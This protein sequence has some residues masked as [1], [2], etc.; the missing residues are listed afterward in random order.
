MRAVWSMAQFVTLD[1][2]PVKAHSAPARETLLAQWEAQ[3]R[4]AETQALSAI[5]D[6]ALGRRAPGGAALPEAG[7]K[8]DLVL[9]AAVADALRCKSVF[10]RYELLRMVNRHLPSYL[11]GLPGSRVTELLEELTARALAPGGP[12]GTVLLTA[13]DMVPVPAAYRRADGLSRGA[14][15]APRYTTRDQLGAEPRL[16][17]VAAQTGAPSIA[18]DRAARAL[19]ANRARLEARLW[20]EHGPQGG[21]GAHPALD[22]A[23]AP[24]TSA[25]LSDDQAQAAYG[26]L[27]SGRAIDILIGAAGTG[28]TRTVAVLARAWRDAGIG[29]VVGLTTS[30]S[31]AHTLAAEGLA[32]SSNLAVFL[33]RIKDS[34]RTRGHRPVRPGDLLVVDE[35]SMVPTGDLAAVEAI[36][37]RV[38]AKIL[39]TGDP[40]QLSSPGAG[41]AMRL[42]ADE[43]GY[44]QL[45]TVQRFD[46][47][48]EREASL[49]LRAAD[50]DVLAEYD[51]RGRILEGTAEEMAAAAVRR[52][53]ADYL[54]GKESLLMAGTNV[55]A[56]DLA[57]RARDSLAALGVVG[58]DDLIELADGNVAGPGDLIVARQN[59]RIVAGEP[60]RLLANRDLL[61]IDAWEERGEERVAVVRRRTGRDPVTGD[62][63]WSAPF[64]L[65]ESYLERHVQ[66]GYAGNVHVA[67][68]RTVDTT[69]LLVDESVGREALYVGLGR[70]RQR[71]TA[72]TIT[73]RTRAA[74][75]S[76]VPR[77]APELV[78][79]GAGG[80]SR[81]HRFTVLAAVMEREQS[82]RTATETVR[83]ELERAASL[84]TLAPMWADVTR[85]HAARRYEDSIRALIAEADW[86]QYDQ[87]AERGTLI[88]LLRAAELAGHDVDSV[89]RHAVEDRGFAG[90]RSIA[91]VLHGRVRR[92]VGTAEPM[93]S[94][95]Y[96]D[97]TPVI[98]DPAARRLAGELAAAMDERVALLGERV[99]ADRP[100]WVL[101]HLG[102]VPTGA[103]DRDEWARRAGLA[104]AYR[105]ER[106]YAS[107]TD[108]LGPAPERASPE[109][110]ASWH[111]AYA[112]LRMPEQDREVAAATDG[113]LLSWR[114]AYEREAGWAPL[115]VV[116]ELRE[117]HIAEDTY[118]ADAVHAWYRADATAGEAEREQA[119]HE[120]EAFSA[121]AQ[122]VGAHREALNE[123]A[124]ARRAWHAAT[125]ASRWRALAGLSA[126]ARVLPL[127]VITCSSSARSA[128]IDP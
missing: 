51:Q 89:V 67:Q 49:R 82:E 117:A 121:L 35:A 125:E 81:P 28:K 44:Y 86:L 119:Q 47:E 70:G 78:D 99:A 126:H 61:R 17:R 72:Y 111:A 37:T 96:S 123:V 13:P 118:R 65:P 50:A 27:T 88:R 42:L 66:L 64:E 4:R 6:A 33:G 104:A 8:M 114:A 124:D 74:D 76:A 7:A 39:L 48:W 95:S 93:A 83:A 71:N 108:A 92:I 100:A 94:A 113:E 18:S 11:G 24:L 73:E 55:Q 87:D 97:R 122:E 9:A 54:S 36:A 80:R 2:R 16:L 110:R 10:T 45:V 62:P 53:L 1:S 20:R 14:D 52:W 85:A 58:R 103:A 56:A 21:P 128:G 105:E 112:A 106:G 127:E 77:T 26:I 115:Y 107:E 30:T 84:A 29:R 19:G 3:S 41:G 34:D 68:S 25:G 63:Q 38:G 102:E 15:T 22:G 5:P 98:D 60:G 23:D 12:C 116:G 109:L 59:D 79:P 46:A 90:A 40:A 101:P 57:R 69:H 32:D 120:A 43:H 91:A 31:A 75:L